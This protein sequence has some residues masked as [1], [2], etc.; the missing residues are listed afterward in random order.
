MYNTDFSTC[1]VPNCNILSRSV[2]DFTAHYRQHYGIP[3]GVRICRHCYKENK[4]PERD[5]C[6]YHINCQTLNLFKCNACNIVFKSMTEFATH[7]L[8]AH[9]GRLLNSSGNYLCFYC[10]K[11]SP[12]LMMI[13]G[14]IKHCR[15]NQFKSAERNETKNEMQLTKLEAEENQTELLIDNKEAKKVI[16]QTRENKKLLLRTSQLSLFTCLK[17]SCNLIFKYFPTFKIHHREHFEIGNKLMCWQCCTP[18]PSKSSLRNH[19]LIGHCHTLGMFKCYECF[20]QYE[21]IERLSIHKFITHNG[22]L[23]SQRKNKKAVPC[24]TCKIE[25]NIN[26]LRNHLIQGECHD[27]KIAPKPILVKQKTWCSRKC[28]ICGKVCLTAALLSSHIK[29]HKPNF[30]K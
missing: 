29:L 21:D 19:Q 1:L 7:K 26:D 12:D 28:T 10:E 15:D 20:E 23:Q 24:P 13:N 25:I 4:M 3:T 8:Q 6:D 18:F 30:T 22:I 16:E 5:N 17:P 27:S 9:N 11:S 14:H 2:E